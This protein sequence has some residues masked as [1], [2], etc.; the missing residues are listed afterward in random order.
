[1]KKWLIDSFLPMWAKET[2][3]AENRQLKRQLRQAQLEND[4][5]K[6][7]IQGLEVGFRAVKRIT[8]HTGG[9]A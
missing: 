7:Y 4:K 5:M 9:N 6:M 1:M 3:L 2:V 8:I